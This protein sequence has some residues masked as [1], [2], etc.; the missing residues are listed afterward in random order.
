M[1]LELNAKK[2]LLASEAPKK[3]TPKQKK[4]D[5]NQDGKIDGEDLKKVRQ[6]EL[7]AESRKVTAKQR[8][9]TVKV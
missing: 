9:M 7:A 2:R 5:I 4:L 8:L 1:K 3:L 6:G